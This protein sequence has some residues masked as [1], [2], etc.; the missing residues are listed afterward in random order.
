MKISRIIRHKGDGAGSSLNA[1]IAANM[2]EAGSLTAAISRQHV[3]IVQRDGGTEVREHA[4]E[5]DE[6]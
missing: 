3:R 1:V 6:Q 5:D 2:G 4:T